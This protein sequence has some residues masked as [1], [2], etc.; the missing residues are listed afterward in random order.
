[1]PGAA[2]IPF[3]DQE[4]A[5]ADAMIAFLDSVQ[6]EEAELDRML[7]TVLFTDIVGST[8]K[9]CRARRRALEAS[10]SSATTR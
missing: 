6:H 9:A 4:E 2:T 7:A 8:E 10:C 5:Y 1:M 3:F